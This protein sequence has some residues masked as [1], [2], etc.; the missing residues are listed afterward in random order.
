MAPE[1][2][3]F[4]VI[5]GRIRTSFGLQGFV[6]V[7]PWTHTPER[8]TLLKEVAVEAGGKVQVMEIEA[9]ELKPGFVLVKFASID[10][11]EQAKQLANGVIKIREADRLPLES[12][13]EFYIDDLVGLEVVTE[14]GAS[15]GKIEQVLQL[16]SCDVYETSQAL[17]PAL[18]ELVKRVDLEKGVM[19][20]EDRPGLR[21]LG[22]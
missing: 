17:I 13:D 15:L 3:A 7:E 22:R 14:A 9:I 10:T 20:V 5:V 2:D 21:K 18:K 16:P 12:E 11:R 6:K 4:E 1:A 8:F 19:I